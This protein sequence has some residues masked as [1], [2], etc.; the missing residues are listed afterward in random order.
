MAENV[1]RR[2]A[3]VVLAVAPLDESFWT[4]ISRLQRPPQALKCSAGALWTCTSQT[5]TSQ[6]D[7][8]LRVS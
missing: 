2:P 8:I 4:L 7:H 5:C 3:A 6:K 1:C